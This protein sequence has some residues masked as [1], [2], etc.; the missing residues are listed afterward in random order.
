M[1][2][3][4]KFFLTLAGLIGYVLIM[5]VNANVDPMNLGLGIG[6]M[7]TPTAVANAFE[8]RYKSG[9]AAE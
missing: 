3:L 7:L 4:R 5:L 2:N 1:N 8:H 9:K 6:F